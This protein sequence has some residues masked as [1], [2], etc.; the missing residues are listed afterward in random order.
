MNILAIDLGTSGPKVAYV[1]QAGRILASE[2]EE[3]K[4][5]FLPNGGAEQDPDAWWSAICKAAK[6]LQASSSVPPE[7]IAGICVTTQ[8]SGTVPVDRE[9]KH[10][11]NAIIWMDSRGADHIRKAMDG[12]IKV[13]GYGLSRILKFLRITGGAPGQSGKDPIAHI[14]FIKTKCLIY[15]RKLIN[16]LNQRITSMLA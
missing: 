9:G 10:L 2:I 16:F 3:T 11:S 8:W 12:I 13:Q 14:L 1:D 4:I 7:S 5:L 15:L 6:R